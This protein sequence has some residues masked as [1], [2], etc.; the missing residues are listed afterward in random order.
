MIT[1]TCWAF[2]SPLGA[3][4]DDDFHLTSIWCA[5]G[6][7]PG[8]CESTGHPGSRLIPAQI[9]DS[10]ICYAYHSDQ[11][12]ACQAGYQGTKP[13][14]MVYATRG[15]FDGLYP[16]LFYATTGALASPN[17]E[18]SAIAMRIMSA[19]I[20]VAMATLL[21]L[22]LPRSR[23]P[24]L[25]WAWL[26]STIPLGLF[27]IASN[28]PSSWAIT[29]SGSLWIALLGYFESTG[30]RRIALG[31]LAAVAALL[32]AGARSDAAVYSILAVIVVLVLSF[33]RSRRFLMLSILPV[34]II[35]V[36]AVFYL[37]SSQGSVAA[38]DTTGSAAASTNP[39]TLLLANALNLPLLWAG[40]FG[41][42]GLGWL[43]T[44]MPGVV[45]VGALVC[46]AVVVFIGL[47]STDLRK[48]LA[49]ALVAVGLV[50]FPSYVLL[51]AGAVVGGDVQPRYILPLI[52]MLTG[53]AL[54]TIG[55]RPFSLSALQR[56]VIV[57]LLIV[58]QA[59]ALHFTMRRYISGLDVADWNLDN[60]VEW[61]WG[62]IPPMVVWAIA[63]VA[64]GA[65]T[66]I[67]SRRALTSDDAVGEPV[68]AR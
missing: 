34:A 60:H 26:V 40:V 11:S 32:G 64:F 39:L 43:D 66:I 5:W 68:I 29:S 20:F 22:L 57:V 35:V 13:G 50:V 59:M 16:P 25:A 38:S 51:Q 49:L 44:P 31:A 18:A 17:I 30:R 36:C 56:D 55:D 27:I 10:A 8:L 47:R 9:A 33:E 7:R 58:A 28:N 6:D 15:N 63:V 2:A 3:S 23:R 24:T 45:S 52:V 65:M 4:P 67:V 54:L 42:W 53:V 37:T 46:F 19:V 1:L 41:S 62:G 14:D 21:Y 61:W 48:K 12:A